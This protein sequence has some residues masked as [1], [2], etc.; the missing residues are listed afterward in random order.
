MDAPQQNQSATVTGGALSYEKVRDAILSWPV[1]LRALLMREIIATLTEDTQRH[2]RK[3]I[4]LLQLYGLLKTDKPAPTDEEE[5][6][7]LTYSLDAIVTRDKEGFQSS[8]VPVLTP[9]EAL[10]Q[11]GA[12]N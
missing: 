2:E 8:N 7:A 11:S 3:R 10:A 6:C 4:A 5:A 9:S 1:S 12:S